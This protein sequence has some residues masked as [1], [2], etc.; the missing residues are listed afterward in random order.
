MNKDT[1]QY[2]LTAGERMKLHRLLRKQ[3][4][5]GKVTGIKRIPNSPEIKKYLDH[6]TKPV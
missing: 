2:V 4:T 1:K 5:K 6:L 3:R